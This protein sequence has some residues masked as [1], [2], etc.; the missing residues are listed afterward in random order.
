MKDFEFEIVFNFN[1]ETNMSTRLLKL[2]ILLRTILIL[3][4]F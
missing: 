2:F 1:Y 3:N 4:F